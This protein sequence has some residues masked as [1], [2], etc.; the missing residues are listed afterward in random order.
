V[1]REEVMDVGA[2]IHE[3]VGDE[4]F[5]VLTIVQK[6]YLYRMAGKFLPK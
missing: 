3:N 5:H 1:E 2:W 6:G 4:I